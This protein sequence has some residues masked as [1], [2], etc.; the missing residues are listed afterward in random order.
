MRN[1][2]KPGPKPALKDPDSYGRP[3]LTVEEFGQCLG[4][5]RAEAYKFLKHNRLPIPRNGTRYMIPVAVVKELQSGSCYARLMAVGAIP[6]EDMRTKIYM[7]G[8][9]LYE[10]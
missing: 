6:T 2:S 9:D 4:F 8:G 5:S 10:K 3:F 7:K 1:A